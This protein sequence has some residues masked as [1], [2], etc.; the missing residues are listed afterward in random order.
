[1]TSIYLDYDQS[2]DYL[3][4]SKPL[5]KKLVY[6]RQ[7]PIHRFGR[8]LVRFTVADLD[9]WARSRRVENVDDA[10]RLLDGRRRENRWPTGR[11]TCQPTN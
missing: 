10:R 8:R 2:A 11:T 4:I 6:S 7:I 1:M 9:R 3:H 5:L